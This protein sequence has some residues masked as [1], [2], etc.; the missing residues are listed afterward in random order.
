MNCIICGLPGSTIFFHIFLTNDT[1][2]RIKLLK[3]KIVFWFSL[4][5]FS[6][7]FFVLRRTLL[8]NFI[9]VHRSACK[10]FNPTWMFSTNFRR[11][12]KYQVSSKSIQW[13]PISMR[14][15]RRMDNG[16]DKV[17]PLFATNIPWVTQPSTTHRYMEQPSSPSLSTFSA[18]ICFIIFARHKWTDIWKSQTV[19]LTKWL[20]L[21]VVWH[22]V[23]RYGLAFWRN[24]LPPVGASDCKISYHHFVLTSVRLKFHF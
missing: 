4:Q 23:Y 19:L 3:M 10:D 22:R 8:H 5:L 6:G 17:K 11:I 2:F 9:N 12:L 15:D 13:V 14:T 24:L 1:T 7:T 16:L 21:L 18:L 20:M